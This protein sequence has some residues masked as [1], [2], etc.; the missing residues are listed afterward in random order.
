MLFFKKNRL[1]KP[2]EDDRIRTQP[3]ILKDIMNDNGQLR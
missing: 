1:A 3:L 2:E